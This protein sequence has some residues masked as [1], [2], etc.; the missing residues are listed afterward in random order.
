MMIKRLAAVALLAVFALG[1]VSPAITLACEGEGSGG[2]LIAE[3]STL[4]FGEVVAG[5]SETKKAVFKELFAPVNI[6][7]TIVFDKPTYE[8]VKDGCKG[9]TLQANES[10][11]VEVKFAPTLQRTE[12]TSASVI[13][14]S[15]VPVSNLN[16]TGKGKNLISITPTAGLEWASKEKTTKE[17]TVTTL[18][19]IE[20]TAME[21]NDKTD[22]SLPETSGCKVGLKIVKGSPCKVLVKR[23]TET[24]TGQKLFK[25][26]YKE[27][28]GTP[29]DGAERI[30][31]GK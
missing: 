10:C 5:T 18:T 12:T 14:M 9:K 24:K 26:K 17:F 31:E 29:V 28:D 3:P 16:L 27:E 15:G 30:L 7:E 6:K 22:F 20:I 19:E 1:T 13:S 2:D 23:I 11:E 4:D 25:W 21:P 8:L